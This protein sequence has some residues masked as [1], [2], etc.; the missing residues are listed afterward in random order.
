MR[1]SGILFADVAAVFERERKALPKLAAIEF[2]RSWWF[3][4]PR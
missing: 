2:Q 1:Y 4:P 3:S